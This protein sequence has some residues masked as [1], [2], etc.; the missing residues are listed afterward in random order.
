MTDVPLKH[1]ARINRA[2]LP[3]STPPDFA[4]AYIDIGAVSDGLVVTPETDTLFAEAPSRARRL[5]PAGATVV[6]T[7]RTYL[8]AV[9]RVPEHASRSFVFSTGFAVLE[10]APGVDPA[11]LHYACRSDDFV[12]EVVA[13]STGVSYPAINP[14]DLGA[15]KLPRPPLDEQRRIA[16]LLDREVALL[17]HAIE[18]RRR[19]RVLDDERLQSLID[20]EFDA[21]AAQYG[22]VRLG[23]SVRRIEQG[24]SPQCDNVPAAP[25]EWGVLKVG[26]VKR[27]KFVSSENKRLPEDLQPQV[28]YA[29]RPGDLLFSRANTPRLVGDAAVVPPDIPSMLILC[30]KLM[31]VVLDESQVLHDYA[32][33]AARSSAVRAHFSSSSTGTSQSMVNIRAEDIRSLKMP[34]PPIDEQRRVVAR[35]HEADRL[36]LHLTRLQSEHAALLKA[37]KQELITAAVSG[38]LHVAAPRSVA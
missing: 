10:A 11:F 14:G 33:W 26:A 6:S 12:D 3:E 17:D 5:A 9:A 1:M 35:L 7:V 32:S 25:D 36:G 21:A 37:R 2:V 20:E 34:R 23:W 31:R 13:R 16:A 4:F 22:M 30:D 28:H 8:R 15:V 18:L 19:Q 29:V 27:G 24:W 38:R